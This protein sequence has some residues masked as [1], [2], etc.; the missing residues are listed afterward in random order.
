MAKSRRSVVPRKGDVD[1]N[2]PGA[3]TAEGLQGSSPARGTWIEIGCQGWRHHHPQA[4]SP[5][6]GTWIEISIP[7]PG[8]RISTVVPRKGDV[9][10]N[11]LPGAARYADTPSSPARGT[12]IEMNL[13]NRCLTAIRV[14]PRKGDVDR[15][16]H[17]GRRPAGCAGSSPARG[18]W[19][20][21][22]FEIERNPVQEGRPPQ[23]GRG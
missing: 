7:R 8:I 16:H 22:H 18:T 5:A 9:D 20:E 19:I 11:M 13:P 1:R 12:W 6:R 4:S 15:N 17:A 21:M 10:R 2:T 3:W 23:G 14:V